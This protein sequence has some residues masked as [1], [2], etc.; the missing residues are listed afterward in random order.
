MCPGNDGCRS[1]RAGVIT[2]FQAGVPWFHAPPHSCPVCCTVTNACLSYL[3]SP[4]RQIQSGR[5]TSGPPKPPSSPTGTTATATSGCCTVRQYGCKSMDAVQYSEA[6]RHSCMLRGISREVPGCPPGKWRGNVKAQ[7]VTAGVVCNRATYDVCLL[8]PIQPIRPTPG[9]DDTLFFMSGVQRMVRHLDASQPIALTDNLW[10]LQQHPNPAAPRCLPCRNAAATAA[11]AGPLSDMEEPA[12]AT[13]AAAAG[14]GEGRP[15]MDSPSPASSGTEEPAEATAAG[16]DAGRRWA[17][18]P[19]SALPAS[20]QG[21]DADAEPKDHDESDKREQRRQRHRRRKLVTIRVP[22]SLA[23]YVPPAACPCCTPGAACAPL[24]LGAS[25]ATALDASEAP[26]LLGASTEG[27]PSGAHS[28]TEDQKAGT[29]VRA[30]GGGGAAGMQ[31]VAL[32]HLHPLT[33]LLPL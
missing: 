33:T 28:M 14:S 27:P 21:V 12:E 32:L 15:W 20:A 7:K 5:G 1:H 11:V 2:R 10:L 9:D 26:V 24:L 4:S 30:R 29:E 23:G 6:V 3:P 31:V 13:A 22:P 16:S 8:A 17:D 25:T 19:S 18:P